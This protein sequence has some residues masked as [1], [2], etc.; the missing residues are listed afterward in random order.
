MV[1]GSNVI[2]SSD[3]VRPTSPGN[4]ITPAPASGGSPS[5]DMGQIRGLVDMVKGALETVKEIQKM[6]IDA[7]KMTQPQQQETQ[8]FTGQAPA[9]SPTQ[10]S[11][12]TPQTIEKIIYKEMEIDKEKLKTF[13]RS[14]LVTEAGKLPEDLREKKLSEI[15]G[16]NFETLEVHVKKYGMNIKA[17]GDQILD[18]IC[19][20]MIKTLPQ[21]KRDEVT[22]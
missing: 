3:L 22:Q 9:V 15:T 7:Q 6:R 19:D 11:S 14:L 21:L 8:G 17:N 18:V 1:E 13:L 10:P 16:E 2:R 5:I 12:M 4:F 20:Q